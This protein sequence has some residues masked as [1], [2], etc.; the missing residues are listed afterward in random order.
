M[1][2]AILCVSAR[3]QRPRWARQ[4]MSLVLMMLTEK[5]ANLAIENKHCCYQGPLA[6][7]FNA[8]TR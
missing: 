4:P 8:M 1:R 2:L 5:W 3:A 6:T 7:Q